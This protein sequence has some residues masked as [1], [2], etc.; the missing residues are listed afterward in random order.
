MLLFPMV[1][2]DI[3]DIDASTGNKKIANS[4]QAKQ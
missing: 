1:T 2:N 4:G 3:L